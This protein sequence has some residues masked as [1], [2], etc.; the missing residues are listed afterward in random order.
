VADPASPNTI[1][2]GGQN[3]GA[4]PGVRKSVDGGK[5]WAYA[6]NGLTD[7]R[8]K[9]LLMAPGNAQTIYAATPSGVFATTDGAATWTFDTATAT[10]RDIRRFAV[11]M[12]NGAQTLFAATSAGIAYRPLAGGTWTLSKPPTGT[13][14]V[15]D[16]E[17]AV[18][19]PS[20]AIIYT[21]QDAPDSSVWQ[22]TASGTGLTWQSTTMKGNTVSVD[23]TNAKHV[24]S[25]LPPG[26]GL[27]TD[28]SIIESL[29]SGATHQSLYSA[30]AVFYVKFDPRDT[31]GKTIYTGENPGVSVSTDGGK[32]FNNL[33]WTIKSAVGYTT[34]RWHVDTQRIFVD[35]PGL[36]AFCSDQGLI[37]RV[38]GS[39]SMVGLNGNFS[40]AIVVSVAPS[41]P[42]SGTGT[43]LITTMWDWSPVVSWDDGQTWP[44]DGD[45][46]PYW[47]SL[48]GSG[49]P[50]MGEGGEVLA[51]PAA[52]D[53]AWHVIMHQ[54]S[55]DSPG[56]TVFASS[57]GGRTFA[58]TTV[59]GQC[60]PLSFGYALDASGKAN[61]TVYLLTTTGVQRSTDYGKTWATWGKSSWPN[62]TV[63]A[64]AVDPK[65]A[66]HVLV[67]SGSC[68]TSTSDGGT[69]WSACVTPS[70][71][72]A[73]L[74]QLT[75]RTDDSTKLMAVTNAAELLRSADSGA[76]WTAVTATN[77]AG[78]V[79]RASPG[80]SFVSYSPSGKVAVYVTSTAAS[81]TV[82]P[83]VFTSPDD[84]TT[85]TDITNDF[86]PS[87]INNLAWDGADFYVATSGDG[88][89][90]RKGLAP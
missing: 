45:D 68:L 25:S 65:N 53:G 61:G 20:S 56:N 88:I 89:V 35:F 12:M 81:P 83:Y 57:D 37:Q 29:D 48:N 6:V 14:A 73:A 78:V 62:T 67:G 87:Q 82:L 2:V 70:S 32:T 5:T 22:V 85:W 30:N 31:T 84:G 19:S 49:V 7:R 76:T 41:H 8:I 21:T 58:S 39:L 43:Y 79:K 3:N 63:S 55:N 16:F 66:N 34:N 23:P 40:D 10:Y 59:A 44:G 69:T 15:Y 38:S 28:Y 36:P 51:L 50:S 75:V 47:S 1:Y 11:G 80:I 86:V 46:V 18:A 24:I 4:A 90:R 27:G 26:S 9:A 74:R 60:Q 17:L 33:A 54:G 72:G 77:V 64:I 52:A 71:R 42:A 13:A